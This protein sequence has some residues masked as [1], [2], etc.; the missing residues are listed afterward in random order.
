MAMTGPEA[1]LLP[2]GV[3]L[4]DRMQDGSGRFYVQIGRARKTK[5]LN[6]SHA[7]A[8]MLYDLL[9]K[10]L[11]PCESQDPPGLVTGGRPGL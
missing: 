7:E 10:F 1:P 6:L 3:V 11:V 8:S 4:V 5:R 2:D 9:G